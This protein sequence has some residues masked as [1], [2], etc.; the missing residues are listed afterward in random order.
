MIKTQTRAYPG[1]SSAGVGDPEIANSIFL[2]DLIRGSVLSPLWWVQEQPPPRLPL[3]PSPPHP[4]HPPAIS[5]LLKNIQGG[6]TKAN[7]ES[8]I[9]VARG[10][11]R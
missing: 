1:S 3:L 8:C 5:S 6:Y 9:I 11:I 2:M 7:I 4:P 10:D